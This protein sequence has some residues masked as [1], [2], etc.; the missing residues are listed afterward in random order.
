MAAKRVRYALC[1]LRHLPPTRSPNR[2][3][4]D[5]DTEFDDVL[6]RLGDEESLGSAG[7]MQ[8]LG[9]GLEVTEIPEVYLHSRRLSDQVLDAGGHCNASWINKPLARRNRAAQEEP[10]CATAA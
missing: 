8:F 1:T 4:I 9:D 5:T 10:L 7:E 2:L 3:V 6:R